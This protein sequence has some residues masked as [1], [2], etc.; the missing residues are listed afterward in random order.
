MAQPDVKA[1]PADCARRAVPNPEA[2]PG[3]MNDCRILLQIRDVLVADGS[4]DWSDAK[5]MASWSGI[6]I[7]GTPTPSPRTVSVR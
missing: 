7:D 3:L 4:L 2:N 1:E 6:Y 5:P